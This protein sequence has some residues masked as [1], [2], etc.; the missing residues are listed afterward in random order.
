[1]EENKKIDY[2]ELMRFKKEIE[3][4]YLYLRKSH[5]DALKLIENIECI[6]TKNID[7]Y[8]SLIKEYEAK[9][10]LLKSDFLLL[11]SEN[12]KIESL[13]NQT[14][15]LKKKR[16]T[17]IGSNIEEPD[18]EPVDEGGDISDFFDIDV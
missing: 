4:L 16:L 18:D 11:S 15:L 3:N 7:K 1:M 14:K 12:K 13:I 5:I 9:I 10:E 6:D 17:K 8:Y 2:N